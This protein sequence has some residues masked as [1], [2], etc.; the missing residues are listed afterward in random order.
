MC[1]DGSTG[2]KTPRGGFV[3]LRVV[4]VYER[5]LQGFDWETFGVLDR[6]S[7]MG[8]GRLRGVVTHGGSGDC[9]LNKSRVH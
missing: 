8:G 7:V 1:R 9:I 5:W 4:F 6:W 3:P 2:K